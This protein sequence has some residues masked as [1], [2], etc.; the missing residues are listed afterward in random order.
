MLWN[1]S[2][3]LHWLKWIWIR[4]CQNNANPTGSGSGS[5][6]TTL[7]DTELKEEGCAAAG[8]GF[9]ISDCVQCTSMRVNLQ[10]TLCT[11]AHASLI[12]A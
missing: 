2:L 12:V 11:R 8:A 4:V 7:S 1:Y 9:F 10:F 3:T 5:G 6:S